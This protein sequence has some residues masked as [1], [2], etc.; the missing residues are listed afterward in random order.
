MNRRQFLTTSILLLGA[1]GSC[2]SPV[3]SAVMTSQGSR[4]LKLNN[5]HTGETLSVTYWAQGEYVTEGLVA[6][7]RLLRDFRANEVCAMDPGLFDLIYA[8]R[9]QLPGREAITVYSGYR[10]PATNKK[11]RGASSGVAKKSYHMLGQALDF[12]IPGYRLSD[13][14]K[15]AIALKAGGVGYYPESGFIHVDTGRIRRW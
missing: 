6:L 4:S 7:N 15:V 9:N 1:A 8:L 10:S 2:L 13:Q 11:L 5:A 12:S 3:A 14:R